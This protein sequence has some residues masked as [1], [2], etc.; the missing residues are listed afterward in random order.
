MPMEANKIEKYNHGEMS[1]K[2]LFIIYADFEFLL[3]K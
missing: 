3:E 2:V 1:T